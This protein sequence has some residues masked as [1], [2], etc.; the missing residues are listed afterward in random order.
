MPGNWGYLGNDV[1]KYLTDN[2]D[3]ESTI[4]DV[5]C[6]HGYY[7]KLLN[8]HFK[9]FDA[10]EIWEPYINEYKLTEMYDNVFNIN[11]LDF[12]FD[13]YDIII[14]GEILEHKSRTDAVKILN[15]LKD[16]C[17]ELIV[18]VP[19]Y[20]PQDEVFGNKYEIH[21]QP[22]LSDD[23]IMEHYSMLEII[24]LEGRELKIPID[25]GDNRYYY[26]AFKKKQN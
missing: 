8:D 16:K 18:V 10:V 4:L 1:K 14:M 11:I 12:E 21:L 23:I 5:G 19:Y 15:K 20:L 9:K 13:H 26:C 6:G 7:F 25:V 24:N 3:T 2:F 22:D 17:K